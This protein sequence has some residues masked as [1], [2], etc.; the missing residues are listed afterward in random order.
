MKEKYN[1]DNCLP[2]TT[3]RDSLLQTGKMFYFSMKL[4][5]E[6]GNKNNNR[7]DTQRK[8]KDEEEMRRKSF[9]VMN[10]TETE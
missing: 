7:A 10:E 2:V 4:E 5:T 8:E 3:I 9:F 6:R 1:K